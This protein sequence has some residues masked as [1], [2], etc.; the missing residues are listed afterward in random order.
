[1]KKTE[2]NFRKTGKASKTSRAA[3]RPALA[4]LCTCILLLSAGCSGTQGT[5]QSGA[6]QDAAVT[7]SSAVQTE[8]AGTDSSI[9]N[10]DPGTWTDLSGTGRTS[11]SSSS[12]KTQAAGA[13][14]SGMTAAAAEKAEES[15]GLIVIDP[16]HQRYAN[17]G[18]EPVGPGA[19][20]TKMK[21]TGGATGTETGVPEYQ[22]TLDIGLKL[23]DRLKERGYE[24][25]MTR[26]SND[27]DISNS[28]RA[29]I[30]NEAN[31]D[32]FVRIHANSV[33]DSGHTG[34]MTICQTPGNVYNGDLYEQ[35]RAL[36]DCILKAYTERTGIE[37]EKVWETD[38]MS[39]INW[40]QIPVT[41]LEMGYLSNAEEDSLMQDPK[42]QETMVEGIVEGIDDYFSLYPQKGKD[43]QSS[44]GMTDVAAAEG[45]SQDDADKEQEDADEVQDYTSEVQEDNGEAEEENGEVQEDAMKITLTR[46][47]F[48]ISKESLSTQ[49]E[50]LAKLLKKK[51]SKKSGKWSL[52]LY[53]TDTGEAIG[54]NAQ[55]SMVS[56]SLIKLYIAGCYLE[57]V[58]KKE[59]KDNYQNQLFSMISAS[60][61]SATNILIDVL[62]KDAVNSFMK[63][64]GYWA[65]KLNRKMLEQNGTENY[66]SSQDCGRLL[67]KVYEGTYV[68]KEASERLMEALKAQI[69]RNKKKIPAG[70]PSDIK[71][72]NKTGELFIK[73]KKGVSIAIQNDSAV[74]FVP[75][76]PYIMTV[77]SAVPSAGE[78]QLHKE[79]AEL[80]KEVYESI[81]GKTS[82]QVN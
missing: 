12:G 32:I 7:D 21:V 35:S 48:G 76:K 75:G 31:A 28:E 38:T 42:M 23:R 6:G 19:S 33:D 17:T 59:V 2:T 15:R 82:G 47:R 45:K 16:G 30:A 73:D 22:L 55:D 9:Q 51:L 40:C 78:E 56:A 49:M 70:V 69:P 68:S 11:E 10:P 74:I 66:T 61:N 41:I 58:E 5:G 3:L 29:Q 71:T 65:G 14:T 63:E 67:R 25:I 64:H 13:G 8:N 81:C 43:E 24:V 26:D 46:S 37:Y 80:S 20:E 39:G 1:M 60:D 44:S 79:I 36:S 72:A 54:L 18:N 52:Y 62:G 27:V 53:R 4:V 77:M 34:A 50:S 57:K